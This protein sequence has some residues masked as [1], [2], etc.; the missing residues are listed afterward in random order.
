[1]KMGSRHERGRNGMGQTEA[2]HEQ[3]ALSQLL[4]QKEVWNV[5]AMLLSAHARLRPPRGHKQRN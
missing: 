3:R 5:C 2:H 4:R 1:M